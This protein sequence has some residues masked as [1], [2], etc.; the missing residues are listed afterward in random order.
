[1]GEKYKLSD[2]RNVK[3]KIL[4]DAVSL[5][6]FVCNERETVLPGS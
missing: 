5:E 4:S 6:H 3:R 2:V 1:M